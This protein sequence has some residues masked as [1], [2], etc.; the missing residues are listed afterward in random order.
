MR[1][2]EVYSSIAWP[3]VCS[4]GWSILHWGP[5]TEGSLHSVCVHVCTYVCKEEGKGEGNIT[6]TC[7]YP[8]IYLPSLCRS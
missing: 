3:L 7:M 5:Q 2:K 6:I 1:L 4:E 8:L